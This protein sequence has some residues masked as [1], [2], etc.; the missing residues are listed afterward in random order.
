M[1]CTVDRG[2]LCSPETGM[3]V[4][5]VLALAAVATVDL[6]ERASQY[7]A[8]SHEEVLNYQS[9]MLETPQLP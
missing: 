8:Y 1:R 7:W 4:K 5:M 3:C 6:V 2:Q 9:M